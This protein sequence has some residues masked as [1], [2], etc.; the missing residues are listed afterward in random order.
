MAGTVSIACKV[1]NGLLLR[2]FDMVE[3][4]VPVMGGGT[5]TVKEGRPRARAD[6]QEINIKIN[7]PA[8]PFGVA[9]KCLIVGGYAIT[10]NVDADIWAEWLSQN[11]SSDMVKAHMIYAH[12]KPEYANK[13][14]VERKELQ[15]GMHP[16]NPE[17]TIKNGESVPVDPRYPRRKG[18]VGAI[19]TNDSKTNAA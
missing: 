13:M 5:K 17:R 14:A 2:L 18:G 6:G 10:P 12:E 7:G 11:K 3:V 16:L 8:T 4:D 9:P 15:S 1:P 19:E